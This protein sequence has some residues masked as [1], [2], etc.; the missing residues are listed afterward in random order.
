[1]GFSDDH[2][3]TATKFARSIPASERSAAR[4]ANCQDGDDRRQGP[5][6][7]ERNGATKLFHAGLPDS[8]I[9]LSFQNMNHQV[10]S[11][12]GDTEDL[13]GNFA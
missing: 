7:L 5:L 4:R 1:M 12:M 2:V 11:K 8:D 10:Y 13:T 6:R 9:S 3:G